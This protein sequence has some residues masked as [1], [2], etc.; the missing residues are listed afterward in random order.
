MEELMQGKEKESR[1]EIEE[2]GENKNKKGRKE[3]LKK[4]KEN[5]C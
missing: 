4:W 3:G 5:N 1:H 2:R